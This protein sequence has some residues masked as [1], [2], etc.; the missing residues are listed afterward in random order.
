M[1]TRLTLEWTVLEISLLKL[2]HWMPQQPC[3]NKDVEKPMQRRQ[4]KIA[5]FKDLF[6]LGMKPQDPV[7]LMRKE[8]LRETWQV[9]Q[10]V[11]SAKGMR[12]LSQ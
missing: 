1:N 7:K 9:G 3:I 12:G 5:R 8:T 2:Q 11:V 10:G 6:S 4:R